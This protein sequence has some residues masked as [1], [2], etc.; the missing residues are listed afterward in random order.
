MFSKEVIKQIQEDRTI[1]AGNFLDMLATL[2]IDINATALQVDQ[3]I[4]L[5]VGQ[6]TSFSVRHLQHCATQ[7]A[8]K[9]C[10]L[11]VHEGDLV[12]L[13]LQDN[14]SY[15]LHYLALT[16]LGA[17]AVAINNKLAPDITLAFCKMNKVNVLISD[18]D[19]HTALRQLDCDFMQ[20]LTDK[21]LMALCSEPV[22]PMKQY[23]AD[24]VVLLAHTS[25]TTGVPKA[26]MFSHEG[27]FFGVRSQ[28]H[29]Q[30]GERVLSALPHS[31]SSAI[32]VL[33]SSL[34]RGAKVHVLSDKRASAIA[35]SMREYRHDL[36]VAFPKTYVDLCRETLN[37]EDFESVGYWIATG[38]ANH[39]SHIRKLIALGHHYVNGQRQEGSVFIDNLGSSEFGFA[40]FR[41]IHSLSQNKFNRCIGRPFEWVEAAILGANGEQLPAGEIGQLGVKSNTVTAGY[42]NNPE[43][44]AQAK[45]A[46]YWLTGDLAYFDERGFF[47][48]VDRTTDPIHTE[49]GTIYSCLTE[50]LILTHFGDIFE[51]SIYGAPTDKAG[52]SEAHICVELIPE[53]ELVIPDKLL[54]KINQVL[55]LNEIPPLSAL[56]FQSAHAHTGVTGKK[57]KRRLRQLM[58]VA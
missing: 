26:V 53:A 33:M 3:A 21:Q 35:Q 38:D 54:Q 46:G 36:V 49:L 8:S 15:F 40:M 11:G 32:S 1:G 30:K 13:Y 29:K 4:P 22:P 50:E 12:G 5:Y 10:A 28:L 41:N 56:T 20:L 7:I 19:N 17:I 44:T 18:E 25:G 31:H 23:Q 45:L 51:C 39:E 58:E 37:Q 14:L 48:H 34:L 2:P 9:Y 16:R 6:Q 27:F 55:E 52:V 24:D 57:L 42:W 43:L 47:Y